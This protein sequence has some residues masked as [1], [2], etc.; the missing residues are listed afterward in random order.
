MAFV[1]FLSRIT[2]GNPLP[3]ALILDRNHT[4]CRITIYILAGLYFAPLPS[5]TCK[6]PGPSLVPLYLWPTQPRFKPSSFPSHPTQL[7]K[8]KPEAGLT[9]SSCNSLKGLQCCHPLHYN[10]HHGVHLGT[11]PSLALADGFAPRQLPCLFPNLVVL[12]EPGVPTPAAAP[13]HG[14]VHQL[15]LKQSR[16]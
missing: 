4:C 1:P 16:Y 13:S 5:P 9:P 3:L 12:I 2:Q 6:F 15:H 14:S 8:S 7:K 11:L 10:L